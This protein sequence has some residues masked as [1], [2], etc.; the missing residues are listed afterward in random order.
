MTEF[1]MFEKNWYSLPTPCDDV[2][3]IDN[4]NFFEARLFASPVTEFQ[5]Q[6]RNFKISL[7]LYIG[8]IHNRVHD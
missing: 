6:N 1:R 3:V 5:T 7:F 4:L 2:I 8:T